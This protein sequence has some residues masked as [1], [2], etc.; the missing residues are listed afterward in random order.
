VFSPGIA[1]ITAEQTPQE[2]ITNNKRRMIEDADY[3]IP[4]PNM[5]GMVNPPVDYGSRSPQSV[6]MSKQDFR[7]SS[8]SVVI[9]DVDDT[10]VRGNSGIK[11][12]IDYVNKKWENYRIVIV[13]ARSVSSTESTKRELD[14]LGVKWDEIYLSDF[15]QGPNSGNAFK[16]YK[17]KKLQE[18][19]F[20]IVE[21]ID[22]SSD[23]RREYDKLGIVTKSPT[24]L[25]AL[26]SGFIQ[27]LAVFKDKEDA[28]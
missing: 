2:K 6:G 20:K 28:K 14:R 5:S 10:L 7:R 12:T 24:S 21:A 4:A 25:K 13:S 3:Q 23:A 19:G 27:G 9:V 16:G 18:K 11:K 22:N 1:G 15:P 17:A 8:S 26:P